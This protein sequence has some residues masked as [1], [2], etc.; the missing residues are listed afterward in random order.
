MSIRYFV[1]L[2]H[3]VDLSSANSK[4]NNNNAP[5]NVYNLQS[6]WHDLVRDIAQSTVVFWK[7]VQLYFE[8]RIYCHL[9]PSHNL[10]SQ[11][12]VTVPPLRYAL[13][14]RS[15]VG[16]IIFFLIELLTLLLTG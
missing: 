5:I 9:Y 15:R 7:T 14:L 6:K 2:R 1:K 13:D 4:V 10:T 16:A 12:W 8:R 3:L 11:R